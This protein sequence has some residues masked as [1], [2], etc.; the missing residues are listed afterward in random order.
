M[1]MDIS[2][3]VAGHIM[4]RVDKMLVDKTPVRI[5]KEDKMM[6]IFWPKIYHADSQV[7]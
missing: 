4:Q 7:N 1:G 2:Y 5:A 6:V 3:F